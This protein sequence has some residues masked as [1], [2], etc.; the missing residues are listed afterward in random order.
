MNFAWAEQI[1]NYGS[2]ITNLAQQA[3]NSLRI[4]DASPAS[5]FILIYQ[6]ILCLCLFVIYYWGLELQDLKETDCP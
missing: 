5:Y 3:R 4:V 2:R 1:T 6:N